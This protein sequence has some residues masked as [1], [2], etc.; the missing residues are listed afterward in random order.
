MTLV[1]TTLIATL[2]LM[3]VAGLGRVWSAIN[4]HL[5]ALANRANINR[6]MRAARAMILSDLRLTTSFS[7]SQS[8]LVLHS[9]RPD[10]TYSSVNGILMRSTAGGG[11]IAA[12]KYLSSTSLPTANGSILHASWTF[13]RGGVSAVLNLTDALCSCSQ[14]RGC[15]CGQSPSS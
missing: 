1:E 5:L 7:A 9:S 15:A 13:S 4:R 11:G 3:L 8:S 2:L 10:V 12:A 14:G 6:E